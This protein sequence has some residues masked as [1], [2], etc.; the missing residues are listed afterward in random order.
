M[1][2]VNITNFHAL[3]LILHYVYFQLY[4]YINKWL[5]VNDFYVSK[6]AIRLNTAITI[7][8]AIFNKNSI[9][10]IEGHVIGFLDSLSVW[11]LLFKIVILKWLIGFILLINSLMELYFSCVLFNYSINYLSVVIL[12]DYCFSWKT[13]I[14]SI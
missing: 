6:T 2:D 9:N 4:W 3:L 11:C 5:Q 13:S 1:K 7:L 14:S 8:R 12:N 10:S